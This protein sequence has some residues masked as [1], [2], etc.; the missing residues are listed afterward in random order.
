MAGPPT[1]TL[2]GTLGPN[3]LIYEGGCGSATLQYEFA[4]DC[5]PPAVPAQVTITFNQR[6]DIDLVT[7]GPLCVLDA[8]TII[9]NNATVPICGSFGTF[10]GP[11]YYR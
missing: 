2:T 8:P 1:G 6:P 7:Q 9:A 4:N 11:W 3:G 5:A 10:S